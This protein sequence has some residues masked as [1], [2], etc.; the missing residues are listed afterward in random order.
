MNGIIYCRVSSK[1][2]AEGTSLDSQ[3]LACRQ[4]AQAKNIR[5]LKSF[6]E[7][8]ESA[9]FADRTQ[10]LELVDFCRQN[11]GRVQ[12]LVVW[13]IDR[14]SRNVSDHFSIKATL[15]KYGVC[16]VSV[17]EPIDA[18]PEGKLM[19][20]I[21][22]GFAQF[23]NDIRAMR[24]VQGMRRRIE[25]GFFPWKPPLGYRSTTKGGKNKTSPDEPD[26]PTFGLL[27]K[28]WKEFATGAYTKAEIRRLMKTWGIVTSKGKPLSPQAVDNLFRNPYYAG[29]VVDPWSSE[30]R[31]GQHIPMVTREIFARVQQAVS[32]RS[33]SIPHCKQR[34]E[35]PLRGLARC[36]ACSHYLTAT[37]SRGRSQR[38]PY[39]LC[40]QRACERRGRSHPAQTVHTEFE[41]FLAAV[42][43]RRELLGELGK[44]I[45][46]AA[47]RRSAFTTAK[48]AHLEATLAR[49]EAENQELIRMR[50]QGMIT[51]A[52]F[53]AQKKALAERR[54]ALGAAPC[55]EIDPKKVESQL[56]QIM[57]PL[58]QLVQTWKSLAARARRRFDQLILPV[59]FVIGRIRTAE[60]GLV[61]KVIRDFGEGN[62][63]GV[64]LSG[65]TSNQIALEILEFSALL[66][67]YRMREGPSREVVSTLS[68]D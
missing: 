5:I 18:N 3:E 56:G 58:S 20:T 8:G 62:A 25:E 29:I 7:Q 54:S 1:E 44:L 16:I 15:L 40:Q 17:T 46:K 9:K 23:D 67:G 63:T 42:S 41:S 14:F 21:L 60:M 52:E 33:R 59:G 48:R 31:R 19:E 10:L 4:Y 68:T 64:D 12:I 65:E 45:I 28:V 32:R 61:F 51:D 26:R 35:F 50:A 38:Y 2:Q 47:E 6:I 24:C 53:L 43:P 30:E 34:A 55:T 49:L 66:R 27:Q 36:P 11:K 37:F 13:K 39:Y 57:E 22:A